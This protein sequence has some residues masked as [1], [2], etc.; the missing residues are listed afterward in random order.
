MCPVQRDQ[1]AA[2]HKE[3]S[4][5]ALRRAQIPAN[6]P[7]CWVGSLFYRQLLSNQT[8]PTEEAKNKTLM[9]WT[10]HDIQAWLLFGMCNPLSGTDPVP[11]HPA[12]LGACCCTGM[13]TSSHQ[14]CCRVSLW[15]VRI[16]GSQ[17]GDKSQLLQLRCSRSAEMLLLFHARECKCLAGQVD[18]TLNELLCGYSSQTLGNN[19]SL[20]HVMGH[21]PDPVP[22]GR[23]PCIGRGVMG[24]SPPGQHRTV[25]VCFL[26]AEMCLLLDL[27]KHKT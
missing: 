17:D 27:S 21:S 1:Q 14:C 10:G 24:P 18:G 13:D 15:G 11:A 7:T 20:P 22:G 26:R 25:Q 23:S 16:K 3:H 9:Q 6:T 12:W 19:S 8:K 2:Q 5:G 4:T